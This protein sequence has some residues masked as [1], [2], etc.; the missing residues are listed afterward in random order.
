VAWQTSTMLE[1]LRRTPAGWAL[2][3]PLARTGDSSQRSVSSRPLEI[4][5]KWLLVDVQPKDVLTAA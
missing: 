1:D 2:E 5:V 3:A 4:S